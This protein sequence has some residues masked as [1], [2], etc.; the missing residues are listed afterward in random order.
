MLQVLIDIVISSGSY[1]G[2]DYDLEYSVWV[3]RCSWYESYN[4]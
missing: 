1:L 4:H 2:E 3:N